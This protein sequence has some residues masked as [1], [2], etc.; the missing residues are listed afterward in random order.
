MQLT[1]TRPWGRNALVLHAAA[2]D[3]EIHQV[4]GTSSRRPSPS[5]RSSLVGARD[6]RGGAS[7]TRRVEVRDHLEPARHP[8]EERGEGESAALLRAR[9]WSRPI[10]LR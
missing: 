6:A 8:G 4:G 2:D 9:T 3:K 1:V 5:H 10:C 7:A